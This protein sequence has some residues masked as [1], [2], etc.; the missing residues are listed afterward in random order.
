[1]EMKARLLQAILAIVQKDRDNNPVD[2]DLLKSAITS[3]VQL[4]LSSAKMV[5]LGD[6]YTWN[7][8]RNLAIYDEHFEK[9]FIS[10]VSSHS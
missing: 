3:F 10:S 4:G 6:D 5:K 7:G 9:S 8:D 2:L 1:M